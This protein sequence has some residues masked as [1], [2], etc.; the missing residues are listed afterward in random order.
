M[1]MRYGNPQWW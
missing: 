1:T